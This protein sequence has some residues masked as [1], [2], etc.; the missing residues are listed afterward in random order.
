MRAASKVPEGATA[1]SFKHED[2]ER[3][4]AFG[5]AYFVTPRGHVPVVDS[6][7][8]RLGGEPEAEWLALPDVYVYAESVGLPVEEH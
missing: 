1:I 5:P 2:S 6:G 4:I 3:G 8:R 7:R